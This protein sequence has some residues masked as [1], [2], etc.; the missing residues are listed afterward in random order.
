MTPG[1][2]EF[3][4]PWVARQPW[5]AGTGIPTLRMVGAFRFEDPDGEVGIETHLLADGSHLYQLPMTYR[6]APLAGGALIAT[7]EHSE[8]G[9]RWIFDAESDPVWRAELLRLVRDG[10]TSGPSGRGKVRVYAVQL[11]PVP[12]TAEIDLIRVLTPGDP[13]RAGEVMGTWYPAADAE[14]MTGCLAVVRS[15]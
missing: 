2:A 8:L 9:R 10:G 4:P 3:L 15:A 1:F 12:A 11:R 14:P 5:Y 6:A 13:G 7:A